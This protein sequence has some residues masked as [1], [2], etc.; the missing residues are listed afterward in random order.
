VASKEARNL[1]ILLCLIILF[2]TMA[3][4][5]VEGFGTMTDY[6]VTVPSVDY[7][8]NQ[9]DNSTDMIHELTGNLSSEE[10]SEADRDVWATGSGYRALLMLGNA[11][12]YFGTIFSRIT[13]ETG[14]PEEVYAIVFLIILIIVA[15]IFMEAIFRV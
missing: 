9:E 11:P 15:F 13:E 10:M 8:D 4:S 7:V 1:L 2:G 14:M 5:V 12:N 6:G 3:T